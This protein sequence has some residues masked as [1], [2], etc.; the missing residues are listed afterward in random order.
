MAVGTTFLVGAAVGGGAKWAYD[1]WQAKEDRPEVSV[2]AMREKSTTA[3]RNLGQ[4][5]QRV[6]GR[7]KDAGE[8]MPYTAEDD[9]ET[10]AHGE[11]V[12]V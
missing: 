3:V 12:S 2:A 1:K 6:M 7:K 5:V 4:S 9:A 10:E 11:A 8:G